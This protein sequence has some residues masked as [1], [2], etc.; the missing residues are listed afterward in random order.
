MTRFLLLRLDLHYSV[1][2][3]SLH[4]HV[5][6]DLSSPARLKQVLLWVFQRELEELEKTDEPGKGLPLAPFPLKRS[7]SQTSFPFS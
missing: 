1:E 5:S 7:T 2:P 4:R 3:G 6:L